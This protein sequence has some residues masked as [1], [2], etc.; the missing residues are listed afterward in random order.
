MVNS[1]DG[2]IYNSY[3]F[4]ST[5]PVIGGGIVFAP[6]TEH[7]PTFYYRGLGMTA[8]DAFTGAKVW[9]ILGTYS[10]TAI[11][12]GVLI[13]TDST[14]GFTYAFGKGET[15]TTVSA[16]NDV[17]TKGNT[18]LLKGTV[19][20]M[21]AAQNG[22]AAIADADQ[23][24]WMEYLHMQ[25]PFPTNA[26]GVTVSLDA[27]DPNNNYV[28]IGNATSD[29]TGKYSFGWTPEIEGKYTIIASFYNT[30]AYYGSTAETAVYVGAAPASSTPAGE[31]TQPVTDL[32]PVLYAVIGIGIAIL[33]AI[34]VVGLLLIRKRQ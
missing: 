1:T 3:A 31:Q 11:A 10:P 23:E 7:S 8:I 18:I 4:G 30:E 19:L 25:Q 14:N 2:S 24:G 6:A 9:R 21:S 15:Q 5:G 27:L 16:Q 20:D 29:T 17:Y 32:T 22:T 28:H 12:Y 34:A 33:I 26:K 13:A